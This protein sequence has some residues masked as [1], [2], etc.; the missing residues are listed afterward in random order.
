[1]VLAIF[2]VGKVQREGT[3]W[4]SAEPPLDLEF[5]SPRPLL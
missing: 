4:S 5:D 1:M 3:F 2:N